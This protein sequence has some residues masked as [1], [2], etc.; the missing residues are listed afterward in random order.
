M[1]GKH[2]NSRALQHSLEQSVARGRAHFLVG[3]TADASGVTFSGAA[4]DAAPGKPAADDTV[5]RIFSMTKAIGSTA[6]MLLIER[7][8]LGLDTPVASVL[9]EFGKLQ[10]LAGWDGEKPVF[11]A[12]R[13]QATIRHL[14]THTSGLEYEF[15]CKDMADYLTR[16][17]SPSCLS[18]SRAA[19][20]YPLMSDPGTRWGYGISIDW[21]GMVV[22]ELSGQP[23]DAFV[24][25]NILQPLAMNDTDFEVRAHMAP[26]LSTVKARGEDGKLADF[27]I[28]PPA[29]PEVYGMGQALYSTPRDYLH[30]LRLFLGGGAVDGVRILGEASV[31]TMMQNQMG[32]LQ[33]ARMTTAIPSVSATFDPFPGTIKTHTIGFMRNEADIPGRRHAGSL[34]WAGVL[35][36]HYWIDPTA[37]LAAVIATQ[38]LPFVE[39]PFMEA[40]ADFERAVYA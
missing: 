14:A 27:D 35:N 32:P 29:Q 31:Q 17:G 26:R 37:G 34:S 3:M 39:P 28:A 38:T 36:S 4:G 1:I 15:W 11:R 10:V 6:A 30:F 33:F 24:R 21:L 25:E 22:Q 23:I 20:N 18:G 13:T 12:P 7:G 2:P 40:Y 16:T 5:L 8:K 19:F 9:P